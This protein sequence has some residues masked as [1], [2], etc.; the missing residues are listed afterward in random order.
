MLLT[1]LM[2]L[3]L[4]GCGAMR[5]I[6]E[7]AFGTATATGARTELGRSGHPVRGTIACTLPRDNTPSVVRVHCTGRTVRGEPIRVR[8]IARDA[9]TPNPRQEFV[10]T[11]AGREVLRKACLGLG[12]GKGPAS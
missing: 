4:C 11:V 3:G 9:D 7:K 6:S 10:V 8:G 1:V 2:I 12:C 5:D